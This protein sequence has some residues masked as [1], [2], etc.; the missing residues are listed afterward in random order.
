MNSGNVQRKVHNNLIAAK[1]FKV[2]GNFRRSFSQISRFLLPPLT[3]EPSAGISHG[4]VNTAANVSV[5]F[6]DFRS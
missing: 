4:G 5:V 2:R 1:R 3:H 6:K